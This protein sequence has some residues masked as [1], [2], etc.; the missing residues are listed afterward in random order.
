MGSRNQSIGGH[1]A[2]LFGTAQNPPPGKYSYESA[3]AALY[4]LL[5]VKKPSA[6]HIPNY[7]CEVVIRA[8]CKAGT[9]IKTYGLTWD[10]EIVDAKPFAPDDVI[11]IVDYYGLGAGAVR[12]ALRT[13]PPDRVIVDCAQSYFAP[14][15]PSL[16]QIHSPRKFLPV[17]D[18]GFIRTDVELEHIKGD[19]QASIAHYQYLLQRTI[20]EPEQSRK[21]Y[22]RAEQ[23]LD[24]ISLREMSSFTRNIISTI[25]TA[26]IRQR[27][28]SNFEILHQLSAV[29]RLSLRLGDQVP[30]CYPLM[31]ENG[32]EIRKRLL[33][34]RIFTPR[35]WPNIEPTT[36]FEDRLLN[37]T[38][39]LPLDHRY[40]AQAMI[41][42]RELVYD[43]LSS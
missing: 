38:I 25:D 26:H 16:A 11:L 35:Y 43:M 9:E 41:S 42:L 32:S 13:L 31:V 12:R 37:D 30:L 24:E 23:R 6:I 22:L 39:F 3:G 29:N 19:D 10:F 15:L 5:A 33:E 8:I 20:G 28:R 14:R 18:G 4:A 1:F 21:A 2:A 34:L 17:A 40:D 36:E 7:I 27:R